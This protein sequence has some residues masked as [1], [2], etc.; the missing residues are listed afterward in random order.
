MPFDPN[1]PFDVVDEA[2]PTQGG[3]DPSQAFDVVDQDPDFFA[4]GG[5]FQAG[6][7]SVAQTL[8]LGYSDEIIA[9][10]KSLFTGEE[11]EELL[12]Q[13]QKSL[14]EGEK[15]FPKTTD[16]GTAAGVGIGLVGGGASLIAKGATKLGAKTAAKQVGK[17]TAGS[18]KS[19]KAA[20]NKIT[21]E[22]KS[23][24]VQKAKDFGTDAAIDMLTGIPG[25]STIG[26]PMLR[27][28]LKAVIKSE[29]KAK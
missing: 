8:T 23:A 6:A 28:I 26:G 29:S 15:R 9:G 21:P 2:H 10:A 18:V 5:Q 25:L 27:R 19:M 22:Q 24:A 4:E 17:T 12:A 14:A 20:I 1:L 3:F 13:E 7:R 11:Y 16:V